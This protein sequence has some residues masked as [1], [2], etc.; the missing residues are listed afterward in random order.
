MALHRVPLEMSKLLT[1]HP[2]HESIPYLDG[3]VYVYW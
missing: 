2:P 1:A 3:G